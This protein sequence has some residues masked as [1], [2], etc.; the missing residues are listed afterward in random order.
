MCNSF[1]YPLLLVALILLYRT[2]F[3][4]TY[5]LP[6]LQIDQVLGPVASMSSR[7]LLNPLCSPLTG[8]LCMAG[9]V[10]YLRR[11]NK[12][13]IGLNLMFLWPAKRSVCASWKALLHMKRIGRRHRDHRGKEGGN[14]FRHSGLCTVCWDSAPLP[15][16]VSACVFNRPAA[17][18]RHGAHCRGCGYR[19]RR[20]SHF[21]SR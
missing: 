21:C 1:W 17:F 2:C 8:P 3:S 10:W 19:Y 4:W 12:A 13:N 7:T 11:S 15:L 20:W 18:Y 6:C 9:V 5:F 14:C 16:S